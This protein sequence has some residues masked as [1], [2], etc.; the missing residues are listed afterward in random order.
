MKLLHC[1]F[2]EFYKTM[3]MLP[4]MARRALLR[5]IFTILTFEKMLTTCSPIMPG[6]NFTYDFPVNKAGTFWIHSHATGQYPKGLRSPLVV[7]DPTD[8]TKY[9]YAAN[10]DYTVTVSDWSV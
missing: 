2:T 6:Q 9:G 7:K 10:L 1:T 3:D 8:A 4:W 5:G